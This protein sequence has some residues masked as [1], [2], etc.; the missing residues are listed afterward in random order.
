M[1][2]FTPTVVC[3]A[4]LHT[5]CASNSGIFD[6]NGEL[7]PQVYIATRQVKTERSDYSHL[8]NAERLRRGLPLRPPTARRENA[9]RGEFARYSGGK[10]RLS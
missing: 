7:S 10:S 9:R 3:F 8:N 6:D 2:L 1:R 5:V 4:L